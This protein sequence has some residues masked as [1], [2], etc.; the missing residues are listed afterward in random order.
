MVKNKKGGSF[1]KQAAILAAAGLFVR[2]VGFLYRLPMTVLIK[3]EGNS[4]YASGFYIYQ[5]LLILS[6]AGLPAAI[7]KM[8]SERLARNEFTN[9]HEVFK[10]SM[11][12]AAIAGFIAMSVMFIFAE[13]LSIIIRSPKSYYSILSLCPTIFIV[14]I[15]SV[16][17]GYFQGMK[18]MVPTA[19]S[20]IVEQ[21]FH[22]FFTVFLCYIF[23]Q[24]SLELGVMGATAGTGIGALFGLIVVV[25]AYRKEKPH[26]YQ[27]IKNEQNVVLEDNKKIRKILIA[28]TIPIILGTAVFSITNLADMLMVKW[29][30]AASG[31]FTNSEIDALYGQLSGKFVTLTTLPVA[32]S[33]AVATAAIPSIASSMVL[34]DKKTVKT[35]LNMTLRVAMIIS[36]PAAVGLGVLGDQILAMLFPGVSEG[37]TLLK[38]G[39]LSVI[40]LAYCQTVTGILQGISMVKVPVISAAVGAVVKIIMNYFLIGIP[41]INVIGAVLS[42]T[43]CYLTASILNT[44]FLVKRTKIIP[45]FIGSLLKPGI[46][47]TA[48]GVLCFFTYKYSFGIIKSN[49]ICV[50]I[51]IFVSMI[52]Y[53]AVLIAVN[54]L[55][56][57]D[58]KML[59]AGGRICHFLKK[60]KLL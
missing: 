14:A 60:Y 25:Y 27:N 46:A 58:V 9:A 54:G 44:V 56:E 59:P 23:V 12:F 7:S 29:K 3:D 4:I 35:K 1:I 19:I 47:A 8:V 34:N 22:A 28:T 41:Q 15:M 43:G 26:V 51:C 20:Q 55:K 42:T 24:K 6:S 11:K 40:F 38:V 36:I 52:I 2:F 49:T 50:F 45:D 57:E 48:M 31:A 16:Y 10:V 53:L 18:T 5:F 21:L 33:T 17:R 39:A 30:L 32:I 37:G 13:P